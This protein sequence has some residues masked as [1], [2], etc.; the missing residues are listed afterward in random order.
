MILSDSNFRLDYAHQSGAYNTS[1]TKVLQLR[2]N[3]DLVEIRIRSDR[4]EGLREENELLLGM[5][6][7][8]QRVGTL[9]DL[10]GGGGGEESGMMVPRVSLDNVRKE[11]EVL[12]QKLSQKEILEGR[13]VKV[14]PPPLPPKSESKKRETDELAHD[15]RGL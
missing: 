6:E 14:R 13:L 3:P 7:R 2:E 4:L 15:R 11:V 8:L 10:G 1:T 9:P 12:S 5:V